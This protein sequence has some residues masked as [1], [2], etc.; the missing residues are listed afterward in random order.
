MKSPLEGKTQAEIDVIMLKRLKDMDKEEIRV[1]KRVK[2]DA[3][4]LKNPDRAS[5]KVKKN[6]PIKFVQEIEENNVSQTEE[7]DVELN[8]PKMPVRDGKIPKWAV[9]E[10]L[11]EKQKEWSE[12]RQVLMSFNGITKV[13]HMNWLG[14][15]EMPTITCNEVEPF[16]LSWPLAYCSARYA[17]VRNYER[18]AILKDKIP[19]DS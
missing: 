14:N 9:I 15:D 16:F 13:C 18:D 4:I 7:T 19:F 8:K 11:N 2:Y 6:K 5:K 1:Y 3:W 12:N 17:F 10:E